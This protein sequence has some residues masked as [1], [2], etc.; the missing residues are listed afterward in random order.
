MTEEIPSEFTDEEK[1][2]KF[3]PKTAFIALGVGT[4]FTLLL[5]NLLKGAGLFMATVITGAIPT[6]ICV[7]LIMIPKPDTEWLKGGG[8]SYST[9]IIKR[10]LRRMKRCIYVLGYG[11]Y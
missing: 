8:Q 11:R 9:L 5:A 10:L 4:L 1:W 7:A 6:I 2:F 3:F